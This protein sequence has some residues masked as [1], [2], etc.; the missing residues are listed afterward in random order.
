[1]NKFENVEDV[2]V[3]EDVIV[4]WDQSVIVFARRQIQLKE[5]LTIDHQ[6]IN[7]TRSIQL[8]ITSLLPK[9]AISPEIKLQL[10][11]K[12]I[13]LKIWL[14]RKKNPEIVEFSKDTILIS[15]YHK[16]FIN[17]MEFNYSLLEMVSLGIRN[18]MKKM[19]QETIEIYN[20]FIFGLA[21]EIPFRYYM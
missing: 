16:F 11:N 6:G 1:M 21:E 9:N 8:S 14:L 2:E 19:P 4:C 5:W 12:K 10:L 18:E 13:Q 17:E 3:E 7:L 15:I 20:K